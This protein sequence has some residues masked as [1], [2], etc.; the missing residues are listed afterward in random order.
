MAVGPDDATK[1]DEAKKLSKTNPSQAE[2]VLKD[3]IAQRPSTSEKSLKN[4]DDALMSLGELYR[5]EEKANDLADLIKTSR[6][7]L[8]SFA[9]AKTAKIGENFRRMLN[10][11]NLR[12]YSAAAPRLFGRNTKLP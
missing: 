6:S 11:L 2:K 4:Y 3:I 12:D 9:K 10:E 1:I 5:G 8:S 7:S